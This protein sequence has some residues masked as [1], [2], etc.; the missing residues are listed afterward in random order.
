MGIV[1]EVLG[2]I[3]PVGSW[4]DERSDRRFLGLRVHGTPRAA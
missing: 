2:H 3:T 4:E 1:G